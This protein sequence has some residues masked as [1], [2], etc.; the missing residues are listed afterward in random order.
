MKRT[1]YLTLNKVWFDLVK[2]GEKKEEYREIKEYWI[3]FFKKHCDKFSIANSTASGLQ[4]DLLV[5]RNGYRTD[6]PKILLKNP[7][8]RIGR[9]KKK[10]GSNSWP[11]LF[12]YKLG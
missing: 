5:F 3:R 1:L 8:I 12:H 10:W 2:S 9:G 6:S 11:K 4:Y 7:K